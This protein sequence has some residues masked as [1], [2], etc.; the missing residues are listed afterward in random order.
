M[1]LSQPF[2]PSE[3]IYLFIDGEADGAQRTALLTQLAHDGDLQQEFQDALKIRTAVFAAAQTTAPSAALT[4]RL[5]ARAGFG[6]A[7]TAAPVSTWRTAVAQLAQSPIARNIVVG[8]VAGI[9]GS[10][11]TASV[12]K[13]SDQLLQFHRLQR[14]VERRCVKIFELHPVML[15]TAL[16]VQANIPCDA[17]KI[18]R[19]IAHFSP[20]VRMLK[21]K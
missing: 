21:K 20:V 16:G 17:Q 8:V 13:S 2:S 11:I 10:V 19:H 7:M 15:C 4:G 14:P 3:L 18:R 1:N 6:G 12:L 9:A 5:F